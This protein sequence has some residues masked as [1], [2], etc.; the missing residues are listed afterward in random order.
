[1]FQEAPGVFFDMDVIGV[2]LRKDGLAIQRVNCS[3]FGFKAK[4]CELFTGATL[5][6][7]LDGLKSYIS[8]NGITEPV[9]ALTLPRSAAIT[10][11][12]HIPAPD[13]ASVGRILA[14]ELEKHIPFKTDEACWAFEVT[15]KKENLFSAFFAAARKNTIDKTLSEFRAAGLEPSF[16]TIEQAAV[17]NAIANFEKNTQSLAVVGRMNSEYTFDLYS[18]NA[19]IYSSRINPARV[20]RDGLP[21]AVSAE[22]SGALRLAGKASETKPDR[23]I[24][25]SESID[26]GT[27]AELSNGLGLA[28]SAL[29]SEGRKIYAGA[30]GA[31]LS[32]AGKGKVNI[33]LLPATVSSKSSSGLGK[34]IGLAAS[35]AGILLLTGATYIVKDIVTIKRLESAVAEA[36]LQKDKV[37]GLADSHNSADERIRVLEEI[38]GSGAP[39]ALDILKDL[40]VMLPQGT[41]LTSFEYNS[42][43][44][45]I[46]GYSD[47]AS[48]QLLRLEQSDVVKDAEFAGPVTKQGGKEHFRIK[49]KVRENAG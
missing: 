17:I 12:L 20:K 15:G 47:A 8:S 23:C 30:Y 43:F 29:S 10:G 22:L 4:G 45:L 24:A 48:S 9:I 21:A 39:G 33:N 34:T 7:M 18:G 1:M 13:E 28:V 40:T 31:A 35:L 16:V 27:L 46:E 44:V 26:A 36:K 6:E 42:G 37:Q 2:E 49:L 14:F 25:V 5:R 41:W 38:K 11:V 32:A 19:P 3:L